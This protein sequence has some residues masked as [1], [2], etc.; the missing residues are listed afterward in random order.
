[1]AEMNKHEKASVHS[2]HHKVKAEH[3]RRMA[4]E[5]E[6]MAIHHDKMEDHFAGEAHDDEESAVHAGKNKY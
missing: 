4:T 3:H 1:M 5:H 6:R 2:L